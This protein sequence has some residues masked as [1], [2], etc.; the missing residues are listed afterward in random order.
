MNSILLDTMAISSL[1]TQENYIDILLGYENLVNMIL[2]SEVD[3]LVHSNTNF[4]AMST[5]FAKK[6]IKQTIIFNGYNSKNI[7][8]A[9]VLWYF[10]SILPE[11]FGGFKTIIKIK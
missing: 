7:F 2:L 1:F 4:S 10:K 8:L 3:H 5:H 9:N 6:K 11:R